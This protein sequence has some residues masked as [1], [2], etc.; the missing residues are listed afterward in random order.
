[1]NNKI[2]ITKRSKHTHTTSVVFGCILCSVTLF[3]SSY[4]FVNTEVTPKW[5]GLFLAVGLMGIAWS[6]LYR[7]ISLPD[8]T[9][10]AILIY[11]T[12]AAFATALS[13]QGILQYVGV[14]SSLNS[15]FPI[16]GSF[17]NPA[18]FASALACSLPLCFYFFTYKT[19]YLKYVAMVAAVIMAVAVILSDSRAGI[20]AMTVATSVWLIVKSKVNFK[21]KA[22]QKTKIAAAVAVIVLTVAL[23]FF[24][25]D[26]ADGRLLIWRTTLDM[27]ADK[28]I[29]GHGTGAFQAKYM[30]YQAAYFDANPDSKYSHLAD[31]VLYPFNEFLRLLAE[32]GIVGLGAV[33][34]LVFLLVRAYRRNPNE[35]KLAAMTSLLALAVFSFFSYPFRYPFTWVIL[36]F[37][38]A[39]ICNTVFTTRGAKI[40]HKE[41]NNRISSKICALCDAFVSFVVR[42][43][44]PAARYF[45]LILSACL[46]AYTVMLTRAEIKWNRIARLSLMGKTAEVLP[47]YEKLYRWL[48]R[49][50]LFLYN[51]AAELHEAKEFERSIAVFERCT[52][53]YNDIDVQMLLAD[54]YKELGKY[55]EAERHLKTAAAM[56][57]V[58][59]MPLYELVKLYEAANR[60]DDAL[61]MAQII[62]DKDVKIPSPTITAIKNEMQRLIDAQETDT[63]PE[64]DNRTSDE[65]QND[66]TRQGE[67][68]EQGAALPP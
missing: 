19:K 40:F 16:T 43:L 21:L 61:V 26:S 7:K 12:I 54:N 34:L 42:K 37:C 63:V 57:P 53:Y 44:S 32:Y 47:E 52:R 17:D 60:K 68:P 46:L 28:P 20:L 36:F 67:T 13:I 8:K 31:N 65:P 41:H 55:T 1:M 5:L 39:V 66:E 29:L 6:I 48:G 2:E 62:I 11:G 30:L 25:K 4:K 49:D 15:N 38:V 64:I 23:Y 51:H 33:V 45:V 10:G 14:L 50:G 59:F 24:K 35:E 9:M 3:V 18:G 22:G 56:C 58:R 27:V